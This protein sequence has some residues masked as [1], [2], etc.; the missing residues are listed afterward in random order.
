MHLQNRGLP[1]KPRLLLIAPPGS[2]RIAAFLAA[3][4]HL[5]A[6]VLIAS[7][8]RYSLVGEIAGGLHIDLSDPGALDI[9][10]QASRERPFHGVIA[11][12]DAVVELGSRIAEALRL[13]HNPPQ[14]ARRSQRKDLSREALRAAGV[15]VPEFVLIDLA[16]PLYEQLDA[17][18]FPAVLKPLTLS[19]SRGVI[20][21]DNLQQAL[22]A[23]A[24]IRRI[25]AA[26]P[27]AD[28]YAVNHLLLESYVAGPEVAVEGLLRDG[29][30][31]AL[32]IFDKPD[33]LEGPYFE[34][35]YYIT[36][37]RHA[38]AIQHE[39]LATAESACR[40]LGLQEG[41]VHAELRI[42]AQG[43]VMMEVA[44]RT[45]GGECARLLKFATGHGL[46]EL[47]IA[48]ATGRPLEVAVLNGAAGVLML[49]IPG[50]GILRRVEGLTAARAVPGIDEISIAVRDGYE[51]VPL[52]EGASYLGFIFAHGKRPADAEAALRAAAAE[53]NIVIAPLLRLQDGRSLS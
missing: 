16:V 36:P 6:D 8:G 18:G 23:V 17:V 52:P 43:C 22:A 27:P 7:Q 15:G 35:T 37:S 40:A 12:D 26:D 11:T 30:M 47:V 45:I 41:P 19:G 4:K 44:A 53:L 14:A 3:A 2:Y 24:R 10:L 38:L 51:L 39:I 32:A 48:H 9:L 49:P 31:T 42:A 25:L 46:E 34:E 28:E 33:P 13:P 50:A 5:Q 21:V 1:V 20:R 29:V